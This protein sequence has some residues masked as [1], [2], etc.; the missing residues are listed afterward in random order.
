MIEQALAVCRLWR[1]LGQ[2]N[3]GFRRL[4]LAKERS[5]TA[6]IARPCCGL[7]L[8][9]LGDRRYEF[10]PAPLVDDLLCRLSRFVEFPMFYGI[11]IMV[12]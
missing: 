12:N 4:N 1:N 7:A 9:G 6:E 8:L 3:G 2:P 5:N 10:G 11:F